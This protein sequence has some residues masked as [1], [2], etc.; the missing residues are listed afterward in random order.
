MPWLGRKGRE[1]EEMGRKEG[2]GKMRVREIRGLVL[3][4]QHHQVCPTEGRNCTGK[5]KSTISSCVQVPVLSVLLDILPEGS[6]VITASVQSL[7]K[8]N[9][10]SYSVIS[11]SSCFTCVFLKQ[12]KIDLTYL[13]RI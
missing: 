6:K 12:Q 11:A 1:K 3:K 2:G 10:S 5:T 4:G 9:G 13:L 7:L 8:M